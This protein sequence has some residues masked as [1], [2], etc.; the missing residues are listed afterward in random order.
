M[1]TSTGILFNIRSCDWEPWSSGWASLFIHTAILVTNKRKSHENRNE[2]AHEKTHEKIH[3]KHNEKSYGKSHGKRN[4]NCHE[5]T[6]EK[7]YE[8]IHEVP[9]V[10][11]H[12]QCHKQHNEHRNEQ[13][14]EQSN[15]E[16]YSITATAWSTLRGSVSRFLH[17]CLVLSSHLHVVIEETHLSTVP[18]HCGE[19]SQAFLIHV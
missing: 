9:H 10:K 2:K 11:T 4:E 5:K 17:T 12:G 1:V 8:K 7:T 6:H 3:E 13:R 19:V 18:T 16:Q 15:E 14:N